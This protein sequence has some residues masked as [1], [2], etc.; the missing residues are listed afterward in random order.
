MKS[1]NIYLAKV[2][3]PPKMSQWRRTIISSGVNIL[4]ISAKITQYLTTISDFLKK[5]ELKL[6]TSKSTVALFTSWT[7]ES[8]KTRIETSQR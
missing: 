3:F 2:P 8:R 4:D 5:R 1:F 6:P 7:K